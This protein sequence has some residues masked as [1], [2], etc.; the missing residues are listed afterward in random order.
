MQLS[1]PATNTTKSS[2]CMKSSLPLSGS[3][4]KRNLRTCPLSLGQSRIGE[5]TNIMAT[6]D[7]PADKDTSLIEVADSGTEVVADYFFIRMREIK[8]EENTTSS[9]SVSQTDSKPSALTTASD[10]ASK[11]DSDM[12]S[13]MADS[14]TY[15]VTASEMNDA[16]KL[17]SPRTSVSQSDSQSMQIIT[18]SKTNR[19]LHVSA[20]QAIS[21]VRL[22][23]ATQSIGRQAIV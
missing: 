21:T 16:G 9:V 13:C 6:R 18:R 3:T 14:D 5:G 8:N 2:R 23:Q 20:S 7:E 12:S 11:T 1:P 15:V 22:H 17:T 19:S 10:I 4:S